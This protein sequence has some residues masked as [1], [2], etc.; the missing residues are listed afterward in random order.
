MILNLPINSSYIELTVTGPGN[1]S[2][3]FENGRIYHNPGCLP[4]FFPNNI[5]INNIKQENINSEYYL[6]E[7]ENIVKLDYNNTLDL[8]CYFHLCSNIT[9]IDFTYF[10]FSILST[11]S[12][13]GL[14]NGC[15]SLTS[16][17]FANIDTSKIEYM[18]YMFCNCTSLK[19]INLSNFVTTK[20]I[21]MNR[22]FE[23]CED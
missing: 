5:Y 20:V 11:N 16:I 2:L 17:N 15:T 6:N 23:S 1:S 13:F 19:S 10:D 18:Q 14:F 9:K 3:F 7:T 8:K 22:I 12:F 4:T 21:S